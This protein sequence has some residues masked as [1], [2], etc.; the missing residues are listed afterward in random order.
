MLFPLASYT[1]HFN[2]RDNNHIRCWWI[3]PIWI[4]LDASPLVCQH[5]FNA[6]AKEFLCLTARYLLYD[7]QFYCS[8]AILPLANSLTSSKSV[9]RSNNKP[10]QIKL[11]D[12]LQANWKIL[13]RLAKK[14]ENF[15]RII[16]RILLP[17]KLFAGFHKE[18][19]CNSNKNVKV[20]PVEHIAECE[21]LPYNRFTERFTFI[22]SEN[23]TLLR[24][25]LPDLQNKIAGSTLAFSINYNRELQTGEQVR[26]YRPEN[27][28]TETHP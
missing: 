26:I 13:E 8:A 19:F 3:D 21:Y 9:I 15:K 23:Q 22:P 6:Y 27:T 24:L 25:L 17:Q 12:S 1:P 28:H 10:K 11:D 4:L 5:H 16:S 14:E 18:I 7:H 20:D 2:P